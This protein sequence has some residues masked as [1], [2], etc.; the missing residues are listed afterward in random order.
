MKYLIKNREIKKSSTGKEYKRA[1]L[2]TDNNELIQVSV[3]PDYSQ[4]EK[5]ETGNFVEGIIE[6]KGIYKNLKDENAP[7][8]TFK[9]KGIAQAMERKESFITKTTESRN[10]SIRMSSACR[11]ATLM[12]TTLIEFHY[13]KMS[14][15]EIKAKWES[16]RKFFYERLGDDPTTFSE[17]F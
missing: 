6:V 2:E 15:E 13:S 5:V 10:D 4:F 3:W 17:P 1:I 9:G 11:D 7:K 16:W 8:Q 14:E 12:L